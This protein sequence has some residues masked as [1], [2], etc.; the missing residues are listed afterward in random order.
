MYIKVLYNNKNNEKSG[1]R[2]RYLNPNTLKLFKKN[3][4]KV[5]NIKK[6]DRDGIRAYDLRVKKTC[7]LIYWLNTIEI[8]KYE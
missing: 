1:G 3:E 8:T 7:P 4:K 2:R 6:N 5:K